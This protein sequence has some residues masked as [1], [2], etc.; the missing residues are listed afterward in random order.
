MKS[1]VFVSRP[2]FHLADQSYSQQFQSGLRPDQNK[3]KSV[4]WL[5]P[6]TSIPVKV[7][8]RLQ[9]NILVR[10]V[11]GIEYLFSDL[12]DVM[13]PVFWFESVSEMTEE[14][15]VSLSFLT[16]LPI[17]IRITA[18]LILLISFLSISFINYQIVKEWKNTNSVKKK[19][20]HT[21]ND[22]KKVAF[23]DELDH[24]EHF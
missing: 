13:F 6:L 10:A 18:I 9:L 12:E 19:L 24:S 2:H 1:P 16:I 3:H 22:C 11:E 21:C 4:L 14:L 23:L 20:A 8:M 7:N 5:E 15:S 17:I